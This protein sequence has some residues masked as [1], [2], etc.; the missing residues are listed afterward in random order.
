MCGICG[1]IHFDNTKRPSENILKSMMDTIAS[2]GP[3]DSGVFIDTGAALGH[4]RLSI[5]DLKTGHQPISSVDGTKTIVYNGEV[6]NFLELK[7]VLL[8]KGHKFRT[9]SDTEVV[10]HAYE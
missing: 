1:Y 9:N 6:Y 7:T 5:I 3:D 2:R 8:G 4:R 10:L